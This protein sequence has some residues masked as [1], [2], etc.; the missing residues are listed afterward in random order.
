MEDSYQAARL[1]RKSTSSWL[2]INVG[3]PFTSEAWDIM[4]EN[5]Y[6][7]WQIVGLCPSGDYEK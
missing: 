2:T 7:G 1:E 5:C 3:N 4:V 6:P